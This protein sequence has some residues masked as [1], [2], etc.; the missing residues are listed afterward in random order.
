MTMTIKERRVSLK[1]RGCVIGKKKYEERS[2]Y[3][4]KKKNDEIVVCTR[5][6]RNRLI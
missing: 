6:W 3:L 4:K 5:N 2:Q 1:E